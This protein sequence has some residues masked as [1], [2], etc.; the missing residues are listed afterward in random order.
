MKY[1]TAILGILAFTA[2]H[3]ADVSLPLGSACAIIWAANPSGEDVDA[4]DVAI[5]PAGEP[6]SHRTEIA[7][8]LTVTCAAAGVDTSVQGET[9]MEVRAHNAYGWSEPSARLTVGFG[10]PPSPPRN[11]TITQITVTV[12]V[13]H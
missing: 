5:G 8:G 1:L 9:W 2:A 3:G 11:P 7:E 10:R 12:T 6:E 13:R 4:Y